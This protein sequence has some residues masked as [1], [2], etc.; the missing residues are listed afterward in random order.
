MYIKQDC[1][2]SLMDKMVLLQI[3]ALIEIYEHARMDTSVHADTYTQWQLERWV[4]LKGS[5]GMGGG[6]KAEEI[7]AEGNLWATEI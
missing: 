2:Y 5:L 4:S 3:V 6:R 1:L 7:G